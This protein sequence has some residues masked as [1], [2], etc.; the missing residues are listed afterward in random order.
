MLVQ[1]PISQKFPIQ[2]VLIH[3]ISTLIFCQSGLRLLME[4]DTTGLPESNDRLELESSG[5]S[6]KHKRSSKLGFVRAIKSSSTNRL[7]QAACACLRLRASVKYNAAGSG[8][9]C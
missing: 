6:L 7:S 1:T 9:N 4:V 5:W 2:L 3:P 8:V